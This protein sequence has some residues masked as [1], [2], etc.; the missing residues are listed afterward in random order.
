MM[1]TKHKTCFL[2]NRIKESLEF[3][4]ETK[5]GRS[6]PKNRLFL[7]KE[8]KQYLFLG[9]DIVFGVFLDLLNSGV[10]WNGKLE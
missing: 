5:T 2:D 7:A 6:T 1:K 4:W 9:S 8:I 10:G 3:L